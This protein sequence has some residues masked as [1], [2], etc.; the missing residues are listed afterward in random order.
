[1]A[2]G[3]VSD[4]I[5]QEELS[6]SGTIHSSV[7]NKKE[8]SFPKEEPL[9]EELPARQIEIEHKEIKHGRGS[10]V[11]NVPDKLRELIAQEAISGASAKELTKEFGVS[12]SSVSAYKHDATST[13][14]YNKP[15]ESLK[16]AN[17]SVRGEIQGKTFRKLL[18]AIDAMTEEKISGASLKVQSSVAK[19]L[20]SIIKNTSVE[21]SYKNGPN[22]QI[23]VFAPRIREEDSYE[24]IDIQKLEEKGF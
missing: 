24:I 7:V 17:D 10:E 16:K 11:K 19:D 5:F 14:T 12:P 3:L 2:M 18:A 9:K 6:K 1:M 15:N 21:E 23:V 4:S 8:D 13:T 22:Q 20:S